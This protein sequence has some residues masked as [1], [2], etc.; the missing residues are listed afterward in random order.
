MSKGVDSITVKLNLSKSFVNISETHSSG[1]RG[2]RSS[3][4]VLSNNP[5]LRK[6]TSPMR[7]AVASPDLRSLDPR[8]FS[9]AKKRS[10]SLST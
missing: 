10:R 6:G 9:P 5:P 2:K 7:L 4:A 8:L 3:S 1:T